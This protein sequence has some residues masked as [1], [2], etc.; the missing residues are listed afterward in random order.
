MNRRTLKDNQFRTIGFVDTDANGK[1]TLR[2]PQFRIKGYYDPKTN[3][4]KD[5]Q[6]RLIGTGNIL[7]SLLDD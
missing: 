7:T 4:T 5:A 1:E 3:Q 6:F 2:D